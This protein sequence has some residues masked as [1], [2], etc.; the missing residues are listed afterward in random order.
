MSLPEV[1][2]MFLFY[3]SGQW[4]DICSKCVYINEIC[5]EDEMTVFERLKTKY[6]GVVNHVDA[7]GCSVLR[8]DHR[9]FS[10]VEL[11]TVMCILV[12]LAATVLPMFNGYIKTVKNGRCVADL[13]TIDKAVTAYILEKNS[14]PGQ[15]SD[16]GTAANQ[17]DPWG[18]PYVYQNLASAGAAPLED[19]FGVNLNT[20]Y[21]LYST[22]WDGISGPAYT[23]PG[24]GNDIARFNNGTFIGV[25]NPDA[26]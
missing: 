9:G 14:L 15:L 26:P 19:E 25:R 10:L 3:F 18:R 24:S 23:D 6:A 21:D 8:F 11:I 2:D 22:G 13:R 4:A 20:D 5:K 17:L 16:I 1:N 7:R 12:A